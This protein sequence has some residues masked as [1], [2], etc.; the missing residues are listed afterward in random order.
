MFTFRQ[1]VNQNK[2]AVLQTPN[3]APRAQA[4]KPTI[5]SAAAP[6]RRIAPEPAAAKL[7]HRFDHLVAISQPAAAIVPQARLRSLG[8]SAAEYAAATAAVALAR[9]PLAP[10]A[11]HTTE[12][13]LVG[14]REVMQRGQAARDA[15]AADWKAAASA[16]AAR[17]LAVGDGIHTRK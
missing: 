7:N 11:K 8:P 5:V 10:H 12:A 4:A 14:A 2:G 6:K 17:I 15:E 1:L 9:G 16:M 13:E 3:T